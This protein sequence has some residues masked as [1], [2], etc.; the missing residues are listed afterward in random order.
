MTAL[1]KLS[2]NKLYGEWRVLLE[3]WSCMSEQML[4]LKITSKVDESGIIMIVQ[5]CNVLGQ[6]LNKNKQLACT[7]LRVLFEK[8]NINPYDVPQFLLPLKELV[9]S[10]VSRE[11]YIIEVAGGHPSDWFY[12]KRRLQNICS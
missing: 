1:N 6:L 12:G 9:M 4:A 2:A 5:M 11:V 10:F 8:D 3:Q 7:A